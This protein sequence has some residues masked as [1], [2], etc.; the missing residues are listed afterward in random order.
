MAQGTVTPASLTSSDE[1]AVTSEP[2]SSQ[3]MN[4]KRMSL[5]NVHICAF[6]IR[7][8]VIAFSTL[9]LK[10]LE[11][12]VSSTEPNLLAHIRLSARKS[13]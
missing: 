10:A 11:A 8:P 5:G 1:W 2:N 4:D 6:G 3:Q 13:N 9:Q 7:F 12:E